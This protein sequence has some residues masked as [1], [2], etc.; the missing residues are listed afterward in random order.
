MKN[1]T[2]LH[3]SPTSS[4][5]NHISKLQEGKTQRNP[6]P[7]GTDTI[8]KFQACKKAGSSINDQQKCFPKHQ[9]DATRTDFQN[10][11]PQLGAA[12]HVNALSFQVECTPI[13]LLT[14]TKKQ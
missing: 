11:Y 3:Q 1:R 10:F 4:Q 12:I 8:G 2:P 9:L 7:N 14:T 5:H 13:T 6:I